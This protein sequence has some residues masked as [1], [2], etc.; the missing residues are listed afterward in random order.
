[1]DQCQNDFRRLRSALNE[2]FLDA[3][4]IL[5]YLI[6]ND[7][8]LETLIICNPYRQRF[9]TTDQEVYHALGSVKEYD[10]F[11]LNRL[12]KL[13]EAVSVRT[14]AR[15]QL[16]TDEIVERLRADALRS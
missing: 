1:M 15:K 11:R 14:V 16:L 12:S 6:G 3:G 2:Y 9:V 4:K 5:R 7:D 10:T 8:K 13:F